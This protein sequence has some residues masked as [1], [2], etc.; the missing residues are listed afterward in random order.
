MDLKFLCFL[1]LCFFFFYFFINEYCSLY[2]STKYMN[3]THLC[4]NTVPNTHRVVHFLWKVPQF[5]EDSQLKKLLSIHMENLREHFPFDH[6]ERNDIFEPIALIWLHAVLYSQKKIEVLPILK[7]YLRTDFRKLCWRCLC[8]FHS[9]FKTGKQH[10]YVIF[11]SH[12][13]CE[14]FSCAHVGVKSL[15]FVFDLLMGGAEFSELLFLFSIP[16]WKPLRLPPPSVKYGDEIWK[17]SYTER[18]NNALLLSLLINSCC[19]TSQIVILLK[20]LCGK[21]V[22]FTTDEYYWKRIRSSCTF[23][24]IN[25]LGPV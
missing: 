3:C 11:R 22:Q 21:D 2:S 20:Y 7:R 13:Y 15:S 6:N 5:R 24:F 9:T 18:N 4:E 23:T 8:V 1:F 14:L 19:S 25:T 12:M 17:L 10:V 16:L